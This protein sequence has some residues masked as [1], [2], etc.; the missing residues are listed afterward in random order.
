MRE[1]SR[2]LLAGLLG[3]TFACHGSADPVTGEAA[4]EVQSAALTASEATHVTLRVSGVGISRDI[5]RELTRQGSGWRGVIGGIPVGAD[6]LFHADAYDKYGT[7]IYQGEA[8]A[9]VQKAS[10][11]MV[12]IVLQQKTPPQPFVNHV[13]FI[14][15]VLASSSQV[16]PGDQL[17]FG[18]TGHDIDDGDVL[19]WAWSSAAGAFDAPHTAITKW[20]A[21]AAEGD[22]DVTVTLSDGRGGVRS[23]TLKVSVAYGYAHG[24]AIVVTDLNTWPEIARVTAN[25]GLVGAGE[26]ARL[27]ASAT[28]SDGDALR[29]AWTDDCAGRF[30]DTAAP[31]PTWNAP[32]P[33]PA[34]GLCTLTVVVTDARGGVNTGT[35]TV[36]VGP[37]QPFNLGPSVLATFQST[38]TVI[39]GEP[40]TFEIEAVDPEGGA[41]TFA[42]TASTGA[43]GTPASAS[44]PS[45]STSNTVGWTAPTAGTATITVTVRD[46]AGLETAGSFSIEVQAGSLRFVAVSAG[47]SYTCG[48]KTDGNITCWGSNVLG[49]VSPVP[50]GSYTAVSA[51]NIHTC[52]VRADGG[53]VCWGNN[54]YGQ[55]SPVPAG[56][57]VAVSARDT[58]SCGLKTDGSVVCWGSNVLGQVSPVPAGPFA[59]LSIGSDYSCGLTASTGTMLCWGAGPG[60]MSGTY[61]A[62]SAGLSGHL[63]GLRADGSLVCAGDNSYGQVSPVPAGTYG[64]VSA[65]NSF[66]CGLRSEGSIACWG[67]NGLGL[68]SP[69][70]A[71]SYAAVSAG[72]QHACGLKGDG[73]IAC[74]GDNT[75]GQAPALVT[76]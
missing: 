32:A 26:A 36:Q 47:F 57:Y 5:V 30:S 11:V 72:G 29:Y 16:A 52:A 44:N 3:L 68:V 43:L 35:L 31:D 67:Y 24:T 19:S 34:S 1:T 54:A 55:V 9:T 70:P 14:D 53:V 25:P 6:R 20:T 41:L 13:P 27:L 21:P 17:A 15:S 4:I 65:G 18:A 62:M 39:A 23:V 63:C 45:G 76:P 73:N 59:T 49:Q 61:A 38:D 64:A 48:L 10:T 42:W 74:W 69:V 50:A 71:G 7:I 58:H 28:D 46:P 8:T 2:I 75:Q 66:T 33:A 22:Y 56:S 37:A 12:L 60:A 51:G 40:V